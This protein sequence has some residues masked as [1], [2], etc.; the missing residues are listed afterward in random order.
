MILRKY[1]RQRYWYA[2]S[3]LR[4]RRGDSVISARMGLTIPGSIRRVMHV[5]LI[6]RNVNVF[7]FLIDF[8]VKE[9]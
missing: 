3:Q 6:V 1:E 8:A 4:F 7:D 2:E 5:S 9:E